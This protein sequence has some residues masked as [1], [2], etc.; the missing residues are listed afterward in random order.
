[1]MHK[2]DR[3]RL[4]F[5]QDINY[6]PYAVLNVP[7]TGLYTLGG[8]GKEVAEGTAKMCNWDLTIVE[9]NWDKCW[10]GGYVGEGML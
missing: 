3:P 8:F 1:M 2:T 9:S 4:I 7:P 10:D 5:A 6:P